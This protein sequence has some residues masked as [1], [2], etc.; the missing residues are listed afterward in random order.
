VCEDEK[1][2]FLNMITRHHVSSYSNLH[3][4]IVRVLA[5]SALVDPT[6]KTLLFLRTTTGRDPKHRQEMSK[7]V[8]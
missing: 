5:L 4:R 2:D 1:S 7:A 8:H 3:L 6:K